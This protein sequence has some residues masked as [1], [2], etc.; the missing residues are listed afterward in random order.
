LVICPSIVLAHRHVAAEVLGEQQLGVRLDPVHL[1]DVPRLGVRVVLG[2]RGGG[3]LRV[4]PRPLERAVGAVDVGVGRLH[5]AAVGLVALHERVAGAVLVGEQPAQER[6]RVDVRR[7]GVDLVIAAGGLGE[8][9]DGAEAERVGAGGGVQHR[10]VHDVRVG[11][12]EQLAGAARGEPR[13][14]RGV[15]EGAGRGAKEWASHGQNP[16]SRRRVR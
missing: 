15:R 16:R 3:E 7:V 14:G 12:V 4:G 1:R 6:H 9:E 5:G 2:D 13:G 8:L 11:D 10:R